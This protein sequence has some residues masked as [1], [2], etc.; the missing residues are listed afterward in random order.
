MRAVVT[1]WEGLRALGHDPERLATNTGYTVKELTDTNERI[2]WSGFAQVM[3]NLGEILNDEQIVALGATTVD[4]AFFRVL[5]LPARMLFGLDQIMRWAFGPNGPASQ[6]IAVSY[7]R[8]VSLAPGHLRL[9]TRVRHG[10]EPS[11]VNLLLVRGALIGFARVARQHAVVRQTPRG[12]GADFDVRIPVSTSLLARARRAL[13][14]VSD[15]QFEVVNTE[16]HERYAE[17]EREIATRI[18]VELELRRS[19][20]RYRDLFES[21]PLPMCVLDA[22]TLQFLAVNR[23]AVRAY[24]YTEQEFAAMSLADIRQDEDVAP[25]NE[26]A[27]FRD[28]NRV[29][30]HRKKDGTLIH[31]QVSSRD[32]TFEGRAA[33]LVHLFDLTQRM[34]L[35][36]Q[37]RQAQ[38]MEAIGQLAGGVAHDFNNLLMVISSYTEL[39]LRN[40]RENEDLRAIRGAAQRGADLTQKLLAFARRKVIEPRVLDLG[41][42][43][44][45][46]RMLLKP[47]LETGHGLVMDI[48]P[49]RGQVRADRGGIEQIV[50]NLAVNARDAMPTGGTIKIIVRDIEV[51]DDYARANVGVMPGP[52]VALVVADTGVGMDAATVARVFEPFFTTKDVGK[53]TGLGLSTVLGIVQQNGAH[54]HIDSSPG[55]G[56]TIAIYFPRCAP[57]RDAVVVPSGRATILVIEDDDVLR[58]AVRRVLEEHG[59][60]VLVASD[61]SSALA[62]CESGT[63]IELVVS[64]IMLERTNGMELAKA[65]RAQRPDLR[66]LWMSGQAGDLRANEVSTAF[67]RKPFTAE[68]LV[69]RVRSLL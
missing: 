66:V 54:I 9:E 18:N 8:V 23:A 1:I 37:L 34:V 67:L 15:N 11:R 28:G 47:V 2:S 25:L 58:S 55:L 45:D 44:E 13:G 20:Q 24:G 43:V 65:L 63:G 40:S 42:I 56:T 64:D 48:A 6:L 33:R 30:R 52:H 50:M 38:K 36:E 35:E 59:Y 39:L 53:G 69:D 22:H 61:A 14:R 5:F 3:T 27:R 49:A 31:V 19:E 32:L 7:G 51:G 57:S 41:E 4:S 17:L 46:M 21:A 60:Q 26:D 68:V 29:W 12:N 62:I 10:Y 16:L